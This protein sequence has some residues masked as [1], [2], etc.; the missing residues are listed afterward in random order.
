M[1]TKENFKLARNKNNKVA[2]YIR[3]NNADGIAVQLFRAMAFANKKG[4]AIS[5]SRIY[6]DMCSGNQFPRPAFDRML[7]E[8]SE[9]QFK[10][11]LITDTTR[12]ARNPEALFMAHIQL[13][14][15]G[16]KLKE[17]S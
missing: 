13:V 16:L 6:A 8:K 17:V 4:L 14:M 5:P 2:L 3:A 1:K 7:S 9:K 15:R 12:L 11:V 10:T